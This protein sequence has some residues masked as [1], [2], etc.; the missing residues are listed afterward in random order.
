MTNLAVITNTIVFY[1]AFKEVPSKIKYLGMVLAVSSVVFL[2][3]DSAQKEG[4]VSDGD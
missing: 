2:G 4:T 3:I 1:C